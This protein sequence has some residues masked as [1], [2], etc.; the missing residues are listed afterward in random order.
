MPPEQR[1]TSAN[2]Q[3]E[4]LESELPVLVDFWASW[5]LPCKSMEPVIAELAEEY[6]G[7]V[8][9]GKL[10]VDQNPAIAARYDIQGV[11]TFILFKAGKVVERCTG[12]QSKSQ[13]KALLDRGF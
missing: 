2:F 13:L 7:R 5:C 11:P 1:F 10:N 3:R 6:A 12:A 4:V 9:I 8:K